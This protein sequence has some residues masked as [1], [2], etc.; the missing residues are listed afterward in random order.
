MAKKLLYFSIVIIFL[1]ES[2]TVAK[3]SSLP[4]SSNNID[5]D[6]CLGTIEKPSGKLRTSKT[7]NEYCFEKTKVYTEDEMI[8]AIDK[9][10]KLSGYSIINFSKT[11]KVVL[12][13]RGLRANEW[14]SFVGIYYRIDEQTGKT[15][16]YIQVRITQDF[17]G[18]W[19][20]NR[21][22]KIG[23]IIEKELF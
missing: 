10:I 1:L 18:G 22:Q 13:D 23:S 17:T 20:E 15:K 16:V 2:C 9:A 5:F 4:K 6:K 8:K 14:N 19:N 7:L 11:E 12:A 21:A 3:L